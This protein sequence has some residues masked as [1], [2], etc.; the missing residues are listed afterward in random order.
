MAVAW[1]RGYSDDQATIIERSSNTQP[2]TTIATVDASVTFYA[3]ANI[4]TNRG[5]YYGYRL[6]SSGGG[7]LSTY[8]DTAWHRF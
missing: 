7:G 6:R 4:V 1:E 8:S 3:D 2:W 5:T